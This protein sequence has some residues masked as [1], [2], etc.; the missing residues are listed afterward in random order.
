[1]LQSLTL[2]LNSLGLQALT[3]MKE[4]EKTNALVTLMQLFNNLVVKEFIDFGWD[5]EGECLSCM[6]KGHIS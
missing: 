4:E 2:T 3:E 6:I 5:T 1:M